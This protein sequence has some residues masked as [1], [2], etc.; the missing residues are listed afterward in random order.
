MNKF[1]VNI[2]KVSNHCSARFQRQIVNCFF[3]RLRM[4]FREFVLYLYQ[5]LSISL[6]GNRVRLKI[7]DVIF[8]GTLKSFFNIVAIG[9]QRANCRPQFL[10]ELE[11][12]PQCFVYFFTHNDIYG[13]VVGSVVG[14]WWGQAFV[15]WY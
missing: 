2:A 10:F 15:I 14:S 13:G 7:Y 5:F 8:V 4:I 9:S 12:T 3:D 1:D 11:I 6:L